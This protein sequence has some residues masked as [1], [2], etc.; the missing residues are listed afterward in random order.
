MFN[1]EKI[2]NL[3]VEVKRLKDVCLESDRKH[4][5]KIED[6][7][8]DY[9]YKLECSENK[10]ERLQNDYVDL[11]NNFNKEVKR[12]SEKEV[13]KVNAELAVVQKENEVLQKAFE[14]VGFDV[15]DSKEMMTSMI[16]A[17][18]QKADVKIIK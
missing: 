18:S 12:E 17:L 14:E 10:L 3:E 5:I 15:K 1:S 13:A 16:T 7:E 4:R 9:E 2:K 8:R 6:L 11:K